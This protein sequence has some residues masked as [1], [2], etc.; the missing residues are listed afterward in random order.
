MAQP[1]HSRSNTFF[2]WRYQKKA[3]TKLVGMK[4][5]ATREDFALH[6][7]FVHAMHLWNPTK[8]FCSCPLGR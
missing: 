3:R 8:Y 1:S 4:L 6:F 2:L 7:F 5:V